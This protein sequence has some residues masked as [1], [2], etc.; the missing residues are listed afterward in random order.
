M[1]KVVKLLEST[2]IAVKNDVLQTAETMSVTYR[3][4]RVFDV[5]QD[6]KAQLVAQVG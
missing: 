5:R 2:D 1:F 6:G 4:E 3:R